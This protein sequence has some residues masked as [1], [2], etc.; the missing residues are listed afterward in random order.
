MRVHAHAQSPLQRQ[1]SSDIKR[2]CG[3]PANHPAQSIPHLQRTIGN[4]AV[5]RLL[6]DGAGGKEAARPAHDPGGAR[7]LHGSL[8]ALHASPLFQELPPDGKP[9]QGNNIVDAP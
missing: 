5:R 4:Q 6:R 8:A 1:A 9:K 3:K 2:P 7:V